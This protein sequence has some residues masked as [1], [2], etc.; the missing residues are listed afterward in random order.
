MGDISNEVDVVSVV[1]KSSIRAKVTISMSDG[2]KKTLN[3][4]EGDKVKNLSYVADGSVKTVSGEV[5]VIGYNIGTLR[6]ASTP[7]VHDTVSDF[8]KKVALTNLVID[9]SE[10]YNSDLRT[11]PFAAIRDFDTDDTGEMII[12]NE[13]YSNGVV[14]FTSTV[15]PAV[16][17][18]NDEVIIPTQNDP[19]T[20][21]YVA[22]VN[23]M[24]DLNT[25]IILDADNRTKTIIEGVEPTIY[26]PDVISMYIDA[27][28][29]YVKDT[30]YNKY[31]DNNNVEVDDST[32]YV[33]VAS[34]VGA[35]DT[36]TINDDKYKNTDVVPFAIGKN[37]F[38]NKP[39]FKLV[40][41][42]LRLGSLAIINLANEEGELTIGVNGYTI[43]LIVSVEDAKVPEVTDESE[44]PP[45]EPVS[46]GTSSSDD[47]GKGETGKQEPTGTPEESKGDGST[48]T[49]T[50]EGGSTENPEQGTTTTTPE[51]GS[52]STPT[53]E[54]T[55]NTEGE[56]GTDSEP[57]A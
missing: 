7:C 12:S 9:C 20:D 26:M 56:Q 10:K 44:V 28:K 16:V 25:L 15:K 17:L 40:D 42:K 33:E 22:D 41:N 13:K 18:W 47:S 1:S 30:L 6:P 29:S 43:P 2:S 24:K 53:G 38:V 55:E 32:Y 3:I 46:P 31:T 27:A 57:H 21:V 50:P 52:T 14:T 48:T 54:E 36:I 8:S 51:E 35:T 19:S 4:S 23:T 37:S 39:V 49:T 45:S 11:I 5:K 34:D